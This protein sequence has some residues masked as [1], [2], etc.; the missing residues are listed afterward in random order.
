[1]ILNI[2]VCVFLLGMVVLW[3]TYGLFSALLNLLVVITAG[4]LAFAMW[5]P[6]AH[7]ML[8]MGWSSAWG[9]GLLMPYAVVLIALRLAVKAAVRKNLGFHTMVDQIG[10]GAF[11]L[12]A[13]ILTAGTVVIGAGLMPSGDKGLLGVQGYILDGSG[14][15]TKDSHGSSLWLAVDR[16][17][18]GLYEA[19]SVGAFRPMG[20]GHTLA[21]AHPDVAQEA[22]QRRLAVEPLATRSA[23]PEGVKVT[24]VYQMDYTPENAEWL[25]RRAATYALMRQVEVDKIPLEASPGVPYTQAQIDGYLADQVFE[26]AKV[27]NVE[28]LLFDKDYLAQVRRSLGLPAD[29]AA[30]VVLQHLFSYT[31]DQIPE[32][33][34]GDK[35]GANALPP[36]KLFSGKSGQKIILVDTS[37]DKTKDNAH[38]MSILRLSPSQ[39]RLAAVPAGK[40]VSGKIYLPEAWSA[41]MP[42]ANSAFARRELVSL[43]EGKIAGIYGAQPQDD[44]LG[45]VFIVPKDAKMDWL[46]LRGLRFPMDKAAV[47]DATVS[48]AVRSEMARLIGHLLPEEEK[49]TGPTPGSKPLVHVGTIALPAA[50]VEF[51]NSLPYTLNWVS[52]DLAAKTDDSGRDIKLVSGVFESERGASQTKLIIRNLKAPANNRVVRL[53]MTLPQCQAMWGKM[54]NSSERGQFNLVLR[55][56]GD[57]ISAAGFVVA[58]VN[59]ASSIHI[60]PNGTIQATGQALADL[61]PTVGSN[62]KVYVYFYIDELFTLTGF[63]LMDPQTKRMLPAYTYDLPE[64]ISLKSTAPITN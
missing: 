46:E 8:G 62:D 4:L 5:E 48:L 22:E 44:R 35:A 57:P 14:R 40:A 59:G 17:A 9:L 15:I 32:G 3:S 60:D 55:T 11:G 31:V 25:M 10:G 26:A 29:M 24:A 47:K 61:R 20:G 52:P 38:D 51:T 19:L 16:Y 27:D 54:L 49:S 58:H 64:K 36:M 50:T 53:A 1:M 2:F 34:S 63:G 45:L 12:L 56:E 6:V 30:E 23:S 21:S 43:M 28:K 7:W 39:V 37:W 18:G 33:A 42:G 13:G 41:P